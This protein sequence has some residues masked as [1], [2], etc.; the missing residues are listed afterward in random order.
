MTRFTALLCLAWM[1]LPVACTADNPNQV[2]AAGHGGQSDLRASIAVSAEQVR[3]L[4][5]GMAAPEFEIRA[6]DGSRYGFAS[7]PRSKPVV[8][9][10]F[11]GTWCPY[12]N[13]H[14]WELREAEQALLDMGYELIFISADRPQKLAPYLDEKGLRYTL[15]SDNDLVAARAFGIAFQVGDD[16]LSKLEKH[17]IDIEEASGRTHHWLPVPATFIIGADGVI[18]FQYVNPDY[19]VRVNPDVLVTAARTS[20]GDAA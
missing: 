6:A 19:K 8:I 1:S 3:P 18:D 12:C 7:G 20:L 4:L 10:F 17:D 5:P 11:R 9:T 14:L 2:S 13:R 15:L 16:Y